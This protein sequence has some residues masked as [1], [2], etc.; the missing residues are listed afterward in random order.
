MTPETQKLIELLESQLGYSEGNGAYTKFG[1]WYGKTVEFDADYS[2][3]PWCDMFLSWAAHKMGYEEWVGQFAY[4][5]AHAEWFKEND[6]WGHKPKPGALV[7]YDWGGSNKIDNIDH[8]GIVTKVVGDTI[9]TIEGNI[10][11][12]VAKRKERDQSKVAGYGYPEKIKERL[13]A[14]RLKEADAKVEGSLPPDTEPGQADRLQL[15]APAETTVTSLIHSVTVSSPA[16][17]GAE[18]SARLEAATAPKATAPSPS[19]SAPRSSSANAADRPAPKKAKHAKPATAGTEAVTREPVTAFKDA[20][21]T[22]AVPS[23][24]SPALIG[25]VLLAALGV[26]AVARTRQLR[27]RPAPAAAAAPAR[28]TRQPGRRRASG[29]RRRPTSTRPAELL[30]T[31]A[32]ISSAPTELLTAQATTSSAPAE[33]LTTQATTSPMSAELLAAQAPVSAAASVALSAP[34]ATAADPMLA[35]DSAAPWDPARST[36]VTAFDS[37]AASAAMTAFPGHTPGD[38][39]VGASGRT[40]GH[41]PRRLSRPNPRRRP[42]SR[43]WPRARPRRRPRG[44]SRGGARRRAGDLE[45]DPGGAGGRVVGAVRRVRRGDG[46]LGRRLPGQAQAQGAPGGGEHRLRLRRADPRPPPPLA[47]LVRPRGQDPRLHR[48]TSTGSPARLTRPTRP[49]RPA[50]PVQPARGTTTAPHADVLV[51]S[52]KSTETLA[53]T[54]GHRGDT[55]VHSTATGMRADQPVHSGGGDAFGRGTTDTF[56]DTAPLRGRRHRTSAETRDPAQPVRPTQAPS[57]MSNQ[58]PPTLPIPSNQIPPIPRIP[59]SQIP[60]N[61][62]VPSGQGPWVSPR[63]VPVPVDQPSRPVPEQEPVLVGAGSRTR[64]SR[65]RGGRHRA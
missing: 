34:V 22:T 9:F 14:A 57:P 59:S 64:N 49:A 48:A 40:L 36:A 61:P 44:R 2:G 55:L 7:F 42:P 19:V 25:P 16:A 12:G 1:D 21:A 32:T 43:L 31:Q 18:H 27:V 51:H 37:A 52:A 13:E 65:G 46:A 24:G 39:P 62:R 29:T 4:T 23:L 11:G 3:A 41:A 35:F 10:D 33:L 20:S 50:R 63:V 26:L 30:T 5:V 58:I 38:A 28:L 54:A 45:C 6:A 56:S 17:A 53:R 8:V 60:S 15:P 47:G